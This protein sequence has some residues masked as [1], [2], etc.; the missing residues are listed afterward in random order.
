MS[1]SGPLDIHHTIPISYVPGGK[2]T[3]SQRDLDIYNCCISP[4]YFSYSVSDVP[5]RSP[6]TPESAVDLYDMATSS[7]GGA[8][9]LPA[10]T[11]HCDSC[12]NGLTIMIIDQPEEVSKLFPLKANN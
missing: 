6:C 5:E 11:G 7:S 10:D 4:K 2:R 9:A 12:K 8:V 1:N 3:A